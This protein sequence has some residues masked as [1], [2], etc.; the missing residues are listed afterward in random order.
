[1]IKRRSTTHPV[2][3]AIEMNDNGSLSINKGRKY[4]NSVSF[5][6]RSGKMDCLDEEAAVC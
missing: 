5:E 3:L 4:G 1:M 6:E 2:D